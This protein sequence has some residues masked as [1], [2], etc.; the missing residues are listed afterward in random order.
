MAD[1]FISYARSTAGQAQTVA[2]ALERLGYD[3][4]IDDA[5]PTHRAFSDVIEE[6]LHAAAAVVVIWSADA[7]KS[8]WVRSEASRGRSE[9]KLV[10][11]SVESLRLPMPFDQIHC[12]DL[13]AWSGEAGHPGWKAV[14]ASVAHLVEGK[15]AAPRDAKE[16]KT[17]PP[18]PRSERRHLTVLTCGLVN[19]GKL[20]A[21]LDPEEWHVLVGDFVRTAGEAIRGY[22]GF[23]AKA[24]VPLVAYFGYPVAQEYA[25]VRAVRAGLAVV[26]AV[27]S[28]T[29]QAGIGPGLKISASAG[30]HVGTVVVS[31]GPSGE[32]EI[33]G[34]VPVI[35][36]EIQKGAEA[37]AVM[38]T[39]DVHNVVSGQ[40]IVAELGEA[41]R[42]GGALRL[43]QAVSPAIATRHGRGFSPRTRTLF[44]GREDEVRVLVGRWERACDGEGQLVL[45]TGEAGIGKSRLVEEFQAR[46]KGEPHLWVECGAGPLYANT[47]FHPVADMLGQALGWRG[48]EPPEARLVALKASLDR[49]G[50]NAGEAAPLVAEMLDFPPEICPPSTLPPEERRRRLLN[51]LA[52]W[53]LGATQ[54][55]PMVLVM[56]D[57]HWMDPSTMELIQILAEQLATARLLMVCTARPEFRQPWPAKSHHAHITVSRLTARQTRELVASVASGSGLSE[58]VLRAV[59][60][61]TDGVPLF[62]EE[63]T[64]LMQAGGESLST[65]DIPA[66]LLDSLGARLDQLG[67]AKDVAQLG[68]VLGR[69]FSYGLIKAVSTMGES[70][71]KSGLEKLVDAELVYVRGA[72]PETTYQFRHALILDA[73]Y[74][75]LLKSR[76]RELHARAAQALAD[77]FPALAESRP[78][79]L[80][81]HWEG[82]GEGQKAILAWIAAGRRAA[83]RAAHVESVEQFRAALD[84]VQDLPEGAERSGL[85]LPLLLGLAVSLSATLG[86]TAPEVFEVLGRA[87]TICDQLGNVAGLFAVLVG[88]CNFYSVAGDLDAAEDAAL[89]CQKI[90]DE[91]GLPAQ[92]IQAA[93]IVGYCRYSKGQLDEARQDLERTIRLYDEHDGASLTFYSPTNPRVEALSALSIV[94]Y[95]IG[96]TDA[97][98]AR[99]D[100]LLANARSLRRPYELAFALAFRWVYDAF[101]GDFARALEHATEGLALCEA[102]GYSTYRAIAVVTRG[103][104]LAMTSEVDLGLDAYGAGLEVMKRM[105]IL[106]AL[107][108]FMGEAARAMV[109]AGRIAEAVPV[110]DEAIERAE[111]SFRIVLP[112]LH[113]LRAESLSRVSL[114]D[115]EGARAELARALELARTQGSLKF[116]EEAEAALAES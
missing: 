39:A 49:A 80:A 111:R 45:L 110:I 23:V 91:T 93:F 100:E 60:A 40:F 9:Q 5:L 113:M 53:T 30:V 89:K 25:A 21:A 69:E 14:T 22:G 38:M 33:F 116:V 56:E 10:Q 29:A 83:A 20:A 12:A 43:F 11:V 95:A 96:D 102:N 68:S 36:G 63:L 42:E 77:E 109:K 27:S 31:A 3:V 71:L 107:G 17:H 66:T 4:W 94:L 112:R 24:G 32:T 6:Q 86:Y 98:A 47:T 13:S 105:G 82:A 72:P 58:A 16:A 65:R 26:D 18:Q 101:A 62:A 108:L 8:E 104:S 48:D 51:V 106:R 46:L 61:R 70:D 1:V 52:H 115:R 97:A 28:V 79:V 64:R 87:R 99:A 78:E 41:L 59:T 44:V 7:A 15:G 75:N 90:A 34:D 114:P 74:A 50:L 85:E 37:G 81:R 76:R 73:A 92:R 88:I 103:V 84:L 57:L 55:Q 19:A 35:A 67:G 54:S 2:R